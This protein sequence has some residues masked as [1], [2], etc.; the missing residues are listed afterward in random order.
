MIQSRNLTSVAV[1]MRN[2]LFACGMAVACLVGGAP[3]L[4][5]DEARGAISVGKDEARNVRVT[6]EPRT[7]ILGNPSIAD[8]TIQNGG[9][10]VLQGKSYG[11]T[12]I[13]VLDGDGSEIAHLDVN[14]VSSGSS[15]LSLYLGS[16]RVSSSC[17]PRCERELNIG[18]A[19]DPFSATQAQIS[20]KASIASGATAQIPI[21]E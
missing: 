18:D 20:G 10:L 7:I 16:A 12:N 15:E 14:V 5:Q 1:G 11:T 6:G 8:V 21:A 13:I 19:T 4:A 9:L 3:A 2:V 17:A